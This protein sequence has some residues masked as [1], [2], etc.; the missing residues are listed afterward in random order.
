MKK[1][2]SVLLAVLLLA[3][4]GSF[5]FA[6]DGTDWNDS[7]EYVTID[8]P[9]VGLVFHFPYDLLAGSQGHID[10]EYGD[11]LGYGAG[12]YYTEPSVSK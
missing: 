8:L 4:L 5:A 9:Q 11:E 12:A 10:V 2:S 1:I 6:D 7:D 3:S